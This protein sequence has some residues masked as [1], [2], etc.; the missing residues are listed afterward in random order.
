[1]LKAILISLLAILAV[2]PAVAAMQ[3][4]ARATTHVTVDQLSSIIASSRNQRDTK[5]AQQLYSLQLTQR[6]S[7]ARLTALQAQLPGQKSR[8]ALDLLAAPSEFLPPPPSEIPNRPPPSV[9]QQQVIINKAL[10]YVVATLHRLPNFFARIQVIRYRTAPP[11]LLLNG[12]T[13]GHLRFGGIQKINQSVAT[14]LYQNGR[15]VIQKNG[16]YRNRINPS[17]NFMTT[18]GEFGNIFTLVFGDLPKGKI[19]WSH[20]TQ[21]TQSTHKTHGPQTMAAVFH[22]AVP[23][24][25]SHDV[26]GYCC[27]NGQPSK[28]IHAYHGELTIDPS[29]GTVL[30]LTIVTDTTPDAPLT[31]WSMMVQYAPVTL[32]GKPYFCPV[33]SVSLYRAPIDD[34]VPEAYLHQGFVPTKAPT[35]GLRMETQLNQTTY[36]HYHLFRADTHIHPEYEMKRP[37]TPALSPG[38]SGPQNLPR[39]LR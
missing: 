29:T 1:M 37:V 4:P 14:V 36:S 8:Q 15:E 34:T 27:V 32:G 38:A 24:S 13:G 10:A 35:P 33:K 20:W 5:L 12:R 3:T 17:V 18:Y 28:Q 7:P 23:K 21:S 6:L 22:Y 31:T 2:P 16:K 11:I 19:A 26:V 39:R 25:A 9:H 30:R